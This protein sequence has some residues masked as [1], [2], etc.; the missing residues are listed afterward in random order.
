PHESV[1]LFYTAL[2]NWRRKEL[3]PWKMPEDF[4]VDLIGSSTLVLKRFSRSGQRLLIILE[5]KGPRR[6]DLAG[7][8][9]QTSRV[10]DWEVRLTSEEKAFAPDP[11][12]PVIHLSGAA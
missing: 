3:R 4:S 5:L 10:N 11:Q 9:E 6:V 12:A 7:L 1:W 2:L 8:V